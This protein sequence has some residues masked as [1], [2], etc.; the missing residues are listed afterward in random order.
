MRHKINLTIAGLLIWAGT[1]S[2]AL[3]ADADSGKAPYEKS[4]AGCHGADGKGNEKMAKILGDK[5]LNIVG[6]ETKKKS[7]EQLLKVIAEGAGKMP[8]SKLSK[9]E[10]KQALGYVRSLAK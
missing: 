10:Q 1:N 7:D 2:A 6:S 5:G 4:C 3:A 8:A 9:D